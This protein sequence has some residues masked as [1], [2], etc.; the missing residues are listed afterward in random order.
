MIFGS[1]THGSPGGPAGPGGPGGH[2]HDE[3]PPAAN[4][5]L[6]EI[7]PE[8]PPPPIMNDPPDTFTYDFYHF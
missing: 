5:V 3:S 8:K 7:A 1:I 6:D 2:V 4:W